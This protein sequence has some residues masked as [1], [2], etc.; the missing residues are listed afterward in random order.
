MS[1]KCCCVSGC[2][3]T[4]LSNPEC[5]FN[6]LPTEVSRQHEWLKVI[7]RYDLIIQARIHPKSFYVCSSHFEDEDL[8]CTSLLLPGALPS[9]H[10]PETTLTD[11]PTRTQ[12]DKSSFNWGNVTL[13]PP[14]NQKV[15]EFKDDEQPQNDVPLGL[16][17]E[18]TRNMCKLMKEQTIVDKDRSSKEFLFYALNLYLLNPQIYYFI[19]EALNLPSEKIFRQ[20]KLKLTPKLDNRILDC[21]SSKLKSFPDKAKYCTV[22][23]ETVNL[24]NNMYYDISNDELVGLQEINGIKTD[25]LARMAYVVMLRSILVKWDQPV[26]YC[27]L[28]GIKHVAQ[29]ESWVDGIITSLLDIGF[30]V[31]ALVTNQ[32]S[33]VKKFATEIK[34]ITPKKHYFVV[35]NKKIYYIVDFPQLLN[36]VR[37]NLGSKDISYNNKRFSWQYIESLFQLESKKTHKIIP[38]IISGHVTLHNVTKMA[39]VKYAAEIFSNTVSTAIHA[40]V[41]T[42]EL[43]E[44]ARET[45]DFCLFL[46]NLFD[47]LNSSTY[48]N[49]N[50]YKRALGSNESQ[51][52][53]L[54]EAL[55]VFSNLQWKLAEHKKETQK[56]KRGKKEIPHNHRTTFPDV[57]ITINSVIS[58]AQDLNKLG[59]KRLLT[60]RLNLEPLDKFADLVRAV[61]SK[62]ETKE[63]IKPSAIKFS[64]N[65]SKQFVK[66]ILT[67]S[68]LSN[69]PSAFQKYFEDAT[70]LEINKITDIPSRSL[71]L[72]GQ[73]ETDYRM[74]L[75]EDH[76]T[77][78][79][80]SYIFYKCQ[81][82]HNCNMLDYYVSTLPDLAKTKVYDV[83]N[84]KAPF[85]GKLKLLTYPF[86]RYIEQLELAFTQV[87]NKGVWSTPDH[88]GSQAFTNLRTIPFPDPPCKCFPKI[89]ALKLLIRLRI[90]IT[91]KAYNKR[92]KTQNINLSEFLSELNRGL[93]VVK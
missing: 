3:K 41:D 14:D 37:T 32:G 67:K 83:Y 49:D 62:R 79:V 5:T 52:K 11:T 13:D 46:N 45:A 55:N 27:L 7:G 63:A 12:T 91:L 9:R 72:L 8:K 19:R 28:G 20:I 54:Q 64:R 84:K 65:F 80:A 44:E 88:P 21:I 87:F 59:H 70:R 31:M 89:Y 86:I 40:Y 51:M 30:E 66:Y 76:P 81:K 56:T 73:G 50:I 57:Q 61:S 26:T 17:D 90:Y 92:M 85:Y 25:E 53:F 71:I 60:E 4:N 18:L 42:K 33:G 35:N 78:Y 77:I 22:C 69:R 2:Q 82:A 10:L 75:P 16:Q 39:T 43:P 1:R 6:P 15:L 48:D 58:I 23:I 93:E 68:P 34:G 29:L 74:Q 36:Y 47:V 24:K 38:K